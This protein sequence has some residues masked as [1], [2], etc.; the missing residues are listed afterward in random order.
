MN[1]GF[2]DK[3]PKELD[4]VPLNEEPKTSE[5]PLSIFYCDTH[6]KK[7]KGA[8]WECLDVVAVFVPLALVALLFTLLSSALYIF[9]HTILSNIW[10]L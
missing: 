10:R 3:P 4:H 5:P 1:C 9:F 7:D 8:V 6:R 2:T